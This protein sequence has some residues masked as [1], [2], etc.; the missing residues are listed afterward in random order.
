MGLHHIKILLYIVVQTFKQAAVVVNS[1][2]TIKRN[3]LF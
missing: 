2:A 3:G 1:Y